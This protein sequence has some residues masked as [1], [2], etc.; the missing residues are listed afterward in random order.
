MASGGW[1]VRS[2][3]STIF[4]TSSPRTKESQSPLSS[5]HPSRWVGLNPCHI[6][7]LLLKEQGTLQHIIVTPQSGVYPLTNLCIMSWGKIAFDALPATSPSSDTC[8]YAL[9][10]YVSNFMSIVIPTLREQLEHIT[11]VVTTGIH[12]VLPTD[13]FDGNGLISEKK[14]LKGDSQYSLFQNAPWF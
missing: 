2:A 6:F 14:L 4:H 10:V 8:L 5:Q 3:K 9:E 7:V 11:M 13:V 12:N 1:I